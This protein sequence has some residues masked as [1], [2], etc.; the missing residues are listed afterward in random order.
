MTIETK[1]LEELKILQRAKNFRRIMLLITVIIIAAIA[2]LFGRSFSGKFLGVE[3]NVGGQESINEQVKQETKNSDINIPFTV[4]TIDEKASEAILNQKEK[5]NQS[6]F[7]GKNYINYDYRFL[8]EVKNPANW[9]IRYD[10][11][12]WNQPLNLL[13]KAVVNIDDPNNTFRFRIVG[14]DNSANES[15][16]KFVADFTSSFA[17]TS[18]IT[19]KVNYDKGPNA[20]IA[21][22]EAEN[23]ENGISTLVKAVLANNK[24]YVGFLYYYTQQQNDP[25]ILELKDMISTLTAF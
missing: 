16:E 18:G 8:F 22:F 23:A 20:D 2:I 24:Y 12:Q 10:P 11:T 25:K 1:S 3:L 21:F 14:L 13:E 4:G 5:I 17:Q 6:G 9:N 15:I 7:T 19:P